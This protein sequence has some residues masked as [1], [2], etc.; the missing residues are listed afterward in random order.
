MA[1]AITYRT[2]ERKNDLRTVVCEDVRQAV[3]LLPTGRLDIVQAKLLHSTACRHP[4]WA[5][6]LGTDP[7]SDDFV[8]QAAQ[9]V[10]I[11]EMQVAV[12]VRTHK[13]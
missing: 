1:Q 10:A 3:V 13:S 8:I 12:I 7:Q 11:R 9:V 5:Q 6:W 2:T 4:Q